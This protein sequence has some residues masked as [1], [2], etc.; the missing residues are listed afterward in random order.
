MTEQPTTVALIHAVMPAIQPMREAMGRGLP[1]ARVLNL[2]DEGLLSE[3]ERRGGLVPECV[4][5]LATQV[6]LAIEAGADAVLLT[7]TA[8]S[9]V[10]DEIQAR[11]PAVPV[12][13]VDKVM[14]E[15]A[16][17]RAARIGVLGTVPAG[18]AQQREMLRQAAAAAGKTVEVIE[19]VHPAAF[20]ALQRGDRAEHDRILLDALP[21]LAAQ[22]DLVLLGQASMAHLA[23]QI[24]ADLGTPVLS[25][26]DLAVE[27]VRQ[28]VAR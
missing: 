13:P 27:R 5:R 14:V 28:V 17:G 4:D 21:A 10:V 8:Y 23:T 24:P 11:F 2:L 15:A 16:V 20:A 22:V 9:P 26:P 19:S 25:S 7:C 1:Q 12:F 6:G 18:I 3:V